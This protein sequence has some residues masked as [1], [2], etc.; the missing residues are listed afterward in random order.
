MSRVLGWT[1]YIS[2]YRLLLLTF[3]KIALFTCDFVSTWR[4]AD[5]PATVCW[6]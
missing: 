1:K 6:G 5:L 4:S 3:I 2:F